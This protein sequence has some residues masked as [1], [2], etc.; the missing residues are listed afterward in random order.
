MVS[1]NS[2]TVL[3]KTYSYITLGLPTQFSVSCNIG[4]VTSYFASR[5]RPNILSVPVT[6]K[7][8]GILSEKEYAKYK[9]DVSVKRNKFVPN[10][11]EYA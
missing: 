4:A 1:S 11:I 10:M 5:F 8:T 9:S 2:E 3:L 6:I 7:A